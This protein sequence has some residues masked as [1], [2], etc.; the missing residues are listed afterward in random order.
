MR[1]VLLVV[2]MTA[3]ASWLA[4]EVH[5]QHAGHAHGG[6]A[7]GHKAAQACIT[8]FEG[9][10]LSGRGFGM[11]FAADQNGYP[12]P[13]HALE[14]KDVLKLTPDQEARLRVLMAGMFAES[15]PKSAI[16][17][18]AEDRLRRV[19]AGG[20]ASEEDVRAATAGVERA[21]TDVRLIHLLTHLRTRDILT[22][23]QRRLY[24]AERWGA[25]R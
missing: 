23:E 3:V 10:V 5:A 11:A 14:L 24:H 7:D 19:F 6:S 12:G 17:L 13:M 2:T 8:E 21:R 9:V 25:S 20:R 18:E 1:K 16:L 15:R 22:E 4:P